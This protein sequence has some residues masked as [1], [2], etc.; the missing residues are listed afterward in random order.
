M[1]WNI[2]GSNSILLLQMMP[3]VRRTTTIGQLF[4]IL[5]SFQLSAPL[6]IPLEA[7]LRGYVLGAAESQSTVEDMLRFSKGFEDALEDYRATNR[8][9]ISNL[10]LTPQVT[11]ACLNAGQNKQTNRKMNWRC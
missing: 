11:F 2:V 3:R 4:R 8:T 6:N 7:M 10:P 9:F 5:T 1:F